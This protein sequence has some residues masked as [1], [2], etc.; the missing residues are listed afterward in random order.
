MRMGE[1]ILLIGYGAAVGYTAHKKQV[2]PR[3]LTAADDLFDQL[4]ERSARIWIAELERSNGMANVDAR[5]GVGVN[6]AGSV[7]AVKGNDT[8]VR[9]ITHPDGWLGHCQRKGSHNEGD[10]WL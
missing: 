5:P 9:M 8:P 6:P 2:I 1:A 7:P 3:L 10:C 4:T